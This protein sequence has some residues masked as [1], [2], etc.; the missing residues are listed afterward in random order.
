MAAAAH[1]VDACCG[2]YLTG[3]PA[4]SAETLMRSRYNA[5]VL[6][7]IDYLV[8]TTLP[9]QQARLDLQAIADWSA[10]SHWLGLTVENSEKCSAASLNMGL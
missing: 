8:S 3:H 10:Q 6:G 7:L 2:H 9:V 1:R 5:Y 4:P